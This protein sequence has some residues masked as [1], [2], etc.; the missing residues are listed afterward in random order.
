MKDIEYNQI[1]KSTIPN[2]CYKNPKFY[3]NIIMRKL[4]AYNN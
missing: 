2:I 1:I 3:N 4:N